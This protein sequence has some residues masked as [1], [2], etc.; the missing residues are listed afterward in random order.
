MS[1]FTDW[2]EAMFG[3]APAYKDET[4]V[5]LTHTQ[6]EQATRLSKLTGKTR[7]EVLREAYRKADKILV[8]R[9]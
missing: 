3:R 6:S 2:I 9:R 4:R 5:V 8:D 7:D 1:R